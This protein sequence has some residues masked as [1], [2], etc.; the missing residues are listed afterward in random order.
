MVR[1]KIKKKEERQ[2]CIKR[3]KQRGAD[4]K[5]EKIKIERCAGANFRVR[6]VWGLGHDGHRSYLAAEDIRV[7]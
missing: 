7:R 4:R 5:D 1:A 2:V 6:R 3:Q